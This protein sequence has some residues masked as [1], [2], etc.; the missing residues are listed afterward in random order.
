MNV[1]RCVLPFC[2]ILF[3]YLCSFLTY[4][5]FSV[6]PVDRLQ[7]NGGEPRQPPAPQ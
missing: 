5:Y 7:S 2:G 4:N 1:S 3:L 6:A